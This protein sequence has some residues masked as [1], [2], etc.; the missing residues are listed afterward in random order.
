MN[1]YCKNKQTKF[2]FDAILWLYYISH[3]IP[4]A[5]NV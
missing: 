3:Y 1:K 2:N 4:I 5:T